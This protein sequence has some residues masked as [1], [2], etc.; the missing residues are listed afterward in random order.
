MNEKQ[1]MT[2]AQVDR[3]VMPLDRYSYQRF[4][5]AAFPEKVGIEESLELAPLHKGTMGRI[6]DAQFAGAMDILQDAVDA[7]FIE[8][9]RQP[10]DLCLN[11]CFVDNRHT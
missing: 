4:L 8:M 1:T 9:S 3:I 10:L 6:T 5:H 7:G 2:S 11:T